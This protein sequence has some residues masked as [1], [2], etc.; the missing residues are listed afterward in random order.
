MDVKFAKGTLESYSGLPEKD[1]GTIYMVTKD[2]SSSV[3][4]ENIAGKTYVGETK[5]A[6]TETNGL[7]LDS[8][9]KVLGVPQF[10]LL[11]END[12]IPQGTSI[13]DIL[14]M[15]MSKVLNPANATQPSVSLGIGSGFS[16]AAT[17]EVGTTV[18]WGTVNVSTSVGRF[19]NNGWTSP[20]QPSPTGVTFSN[21]NV[22]RT[23]KGFDGSFNAEVVTNGEV[24]SFQDT[25]NGLTIGE[26]EFTVTYTGKADNTAASN[27]PVDNTNTPYTTPGAAQ[28][29]AANQKATSTA[30]RT[31]TGARKYFAGCLTEIPGSFNSET[32]RGLN[33]SALNP[34]KGTKFT[35]SMPVGTKAVIITFPSSIGTLADVTSQALGGASIID[36]FT[37]SEDVQVNG[38]NNFTATTYKVYMWSIPAGAAGADTLSVTI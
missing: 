37:P 7:Y 31:W 4:G 16:N 6:D 19:N 9:I 24:T 11:R 15:M 33:V 17:L 14:K 23:V 30:T 38:A 29:N 18:N 32:V 26:G 13:T 10:G 8:D 2:V 3:S 21:L 12:L 22:T 20:S 25:Q 1:A 36:S 35:I 28:I 5:I 34:R 27:N